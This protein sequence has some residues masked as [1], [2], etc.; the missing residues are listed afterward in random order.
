[1]ENPAIKNGVIAGL[2]LVLGSLIPYFIDPTLYLNPWIQF[3]LFIVY[4]V[5][6]TKTGNEV[7]AL[8]GGHIS[9]G[10]AFKPIFLTGFIAAFM[11][12]VFQYVLFNFLDP[13]VWE[14]Q[15]QLSLE[16]FDSLIE[17][18]WAN[19]EDLEA[20]IEKIENSVFTIVE[21]LKAFGGGCLMGLIPSAII[22]AI[23]KKD[24][25]N[26]LDYA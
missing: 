20:D 25:P 8:N 17:S 22:A 7:R 11:G 3:S 1:M 24:N 18:G 21:A 5:F 14:L 4:I 13:S 15:K 12:V 9:W 16:V 19:E 2:F 10:E 6:M 23:V 26:D